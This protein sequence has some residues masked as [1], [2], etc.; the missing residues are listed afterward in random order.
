MILLLVVCMMPA[1]GA[2][3]TFAS[4][5]GS[6][7][8]NTGN[9]YNITPHPA[10]D[11][12]AGASWVSAYPNTGYNGVVLPNWSSGPATMTFTQQFFLPS[13]VN[14]GSA[15]FGADDTMAVWLNGTLLK[16]ANFTM[17]GACADGPIA[18]EPG[19]FMNLL[20][21]PYLQQGTNTL[22]MEVYQLGGGPTGA[23]WS[24]TAESVPEPTTVALMGLGLL[25]LGY[26]R[27]KRASRRS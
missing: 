27:H 26:I 3:V 8:S 24:G 13:A 6:A 20:L 5:D 23:I 18:C 19:E 22:V 2:T 10:W 25:G 9:V 12:L 17:D 14:S 15:T 11:T 7:T 1:I 16:P 4:G 21:T